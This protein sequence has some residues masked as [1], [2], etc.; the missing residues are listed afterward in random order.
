M[1]FGTFKY[2]LACAEKFQEMVLNLVAN[3]SFRLEV[4]REMNPP[5]QV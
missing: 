4:Y 3:V 2:I 5:P 1:Y